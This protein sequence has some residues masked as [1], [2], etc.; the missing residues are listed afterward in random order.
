MKMKQA[1][2]ALLATTMMTAA[3]PC[4]NANAADSVAISVGDATAAPGATFSVDVSLADIPTTGLCAVEFAVEFDT[5]LVTIDNVTAGA[6]CDTGA[7]SAES[8]I[9]ASL[10][11]TTFDW[12][13]ADDQICI[14]WVTGLTDS[15]Y[16]LQEGGVFVTIEG[17]VS[18][19]AA[20][21]ATADFTVAPIARS[22]YPGSETANAEVLAGYLDNSGAAKNYT[23]VLDGG[24]L[25]VSGGN[26][27]N[28]LYGDV[29]CDK[30]VSIT[31]LVLLA[32]YASQGE[33]VSV[34][35]EGLVNADCDLSGS[36]DAG[37]ITAI[38]LYLA[39]LGTLGPQ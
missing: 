39:G 31:D 35:A 5:S 15:A 1:A 21:G 12:N 9:D 4:M 19:E 34:S 32:R 14:T 18:A 25:T 6:L 2:A 13:V 26:T 16:W 20:A 22:I 33:G 30:S 11:D 10:A 37:D 3:L 24:T 36:V 23:S 17:T 8:A 29:D 27:G 28:T 7:E 38:S